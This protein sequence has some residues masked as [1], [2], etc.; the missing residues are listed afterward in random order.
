MCGRYVLSKPHNVVDRFGVAQSKMPLEPKF[1][2]APSQVMPVVLQESSGEVVLEGLKWGLVPFWSKEPKAE[3]STINA[4]AEGID[5]KPAYR[6]PIRSQRCIIPATGFYEWEKTPHGK[7]PHF[8]HLKTDEIFGFA[9]LYDIYRDKEGQE[10]KTFT[11]ITTEANSLVEKLHN[12]MPVILHREN[13]A[14]W[15]DRETTDVHQ[16]LRL[17]KPYPADLMEVYPV[18]RRVNSPEVDE[19]ELLQAAS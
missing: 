15:L 10:L 7:V 8:I 13:E 17:L 11:I 14:E 12:R 19:P 16:V 1:N 5:T 3:Y 9:G 18:S 4:R 2:I 6:K